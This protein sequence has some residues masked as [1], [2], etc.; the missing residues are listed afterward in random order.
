MC[1]KCKQKGHISTKCPTKNKKNADEK[2]V[3]ELHFFGKKISKIVNLNIDL[4]IKGKLKLL[5]D[6]GADVS[7]IKANMIDAEATYNPENAI[8]L[9]GINSNNIRSFG[10]VKCNVQFK[11]AV[12]E[13]EFHLAP[14][15]LNI[16]YDGINGTDFFEAYN[17]TICYRTKTLKYKNKTI[18]FESYEGKGNSINKSEKLEIAIPARS[19]KIVKIPVS[20]N[21]P[22]EGILEKCELR[23]GVFLAET[24]T[25]VNDN[26]CISSVINTNEK[27]EIITLEEI[28]LE[29]LEE[30]TENDK[31][32][33]VVNVAE[34]TEND[35]IEKL[36]KSLRLDHLNSEEKQSV[37][38]ICSE[39][40]DVFHLEGDLLTTTN[41]GEHSIKLKEDVNP[42]KCK[43]YRL[44]ESQKDEIAKQCKE[45]LKNNIIEPTK[46]PWNAPI[47]L[48]RKKM[49][50]SGEM[51]WRLVVD[52]RKLNE[53][54]K[55]D[56]YP[57]PNIDEI[58]D[59]LG[60]SVY[61]TLVDLSS[62]YHQVLVDEKDKDKTAFSTPFGHFNF[63]RMPFGLKSDPATFQRI[64][65]T[66]LCG[67]QGE[68]LF[69]YIDDGV[70]YAR[71]LLEHENKLRQFFLRLRD[72]NLKLNPLK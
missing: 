14:K 71:S 33:N 50:A 7:L 11:D 69:L 5:V 18:P 27:D 34:Q 51:K 40:N 56:A 59:Q 29:I 16:R 38:K 54:T 46:S 60:R 28:S 26:I 65:D 3:G 62:G 42:I 41:A 15:S 24:L 30:H 72:A 12:L 8:T 58:L 23:P 37:I 63:L 47:L 20:E 1:F 17:I 43:S 44:P 19:T 39:F 55:D 25:T 35:R 4:A 61:F 10:T 9:Q 2:K 68:T 66:I 45:M 6:T 70:I 36:N 13:H 22:K 31:E 49:D 21:S 32:I 48:V 57:L 53:I 67:L 64:M 52:Y